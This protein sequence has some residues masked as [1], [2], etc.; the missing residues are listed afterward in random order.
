MTSIV[1][2]DQQTRQFNEVECDSRVLLRLLCLRL[3]RPVTTN[4]RVCGMPA[5]ETTFVSSSIEKFKYEHWR[6]GV[7]G[8]LQWFVAVAEC[9]DSSRHYSSLHLKEIK[10]FITHCHKNST[11][12]VRLLVEKCVSRRTPTSSM[13]PIN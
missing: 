4:V 8:A 9:S 11:D 7:C 6:V 13:T 1:A 2:L 3:T 12:S 5:G 10:N